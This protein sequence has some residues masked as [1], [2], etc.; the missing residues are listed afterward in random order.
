VVAAPSA[1]PV[2]VNRRG[3]AEVLVDGVVQQHGEHGADAGDGGCGVMHAELLSHSVTPRAMID[4]GVSAL[5]ASIGGIGGCPFAPAATGNLATEDLLYTLR[6][7]GIDIDVRLASV[8]DS[9][10]WPAERLGQPT[11]ALLGRAGPFPR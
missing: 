8:I 10:R 4:C 7:S 5:D 2:P 3:G 6:R 9:A 1:A 11:L